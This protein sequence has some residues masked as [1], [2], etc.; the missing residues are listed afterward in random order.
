MKGKL[1]KARIAILNAR[2][3]VLNWW[4]VTVSVPAQN[5]YWKIKDILTD[6]GGIRAWWIRRCLCVGLLGHKCNWVQDDSHMPLLGWKEYRCSWC[7][8]DKIVEVPRPDFARKSG[9]TEKD[10]EA[11]E[12]FHAEHGSLT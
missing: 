10:R 12:A 3:A 8:D 4:W 1:F 9:W 11:Y 6:E 5:R 7:G 2:I